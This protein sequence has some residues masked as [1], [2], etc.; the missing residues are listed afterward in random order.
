MGRAWQRYILLEERLELR[1]HFGITNVTV[2][3]S[4]RNDGGQTR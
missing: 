4:A 2:E 3:K 1:R